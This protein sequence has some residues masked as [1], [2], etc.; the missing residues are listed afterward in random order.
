MTRR[1]FTLV[2]IVVAVALTGIVVTLAAEMFRAV[3]AGARQVEWHRAALDQR[4]NASRWLGRTLGNLEVGTSGVSSF[5]GAPDAIRCTTWVPSPLGWLE[6]TD[7]HLRF[8]DSTVTVSF[9]S[10]GAVTLWREVASMHIDYLLVPG[11]ESGWVDRWESPVSAPVAIRLRL[12]R[13]DGSATVD[14]L[15]F[16]IGSRG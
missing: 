5:R 3:E 4:V 7:I 14:T 8:G 16:A 11:S 13:A 12:A 1:G 15:L 6:R 2:E 9:A 10:G